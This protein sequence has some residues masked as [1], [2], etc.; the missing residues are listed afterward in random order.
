[1]LVFPPYCPMTADDARHRIAE[2]QRLESAGEL[3]DAVEA[4]RSVV[5]ELERGPG[6]V[7]ELADAHAGLIR[8]LYFHSTTARVMRAY[9]KYLAECA[10]PCDAQYDEIYSDGLIATDSCP[11]P[12]RRRERFHSLAGLFQRTRGLPGAV[13]ECGCFTGLSS[14]LLCR[15]LKLEDARFDGTGYEI[16]DSFAGLSAPQPEDEIPE[17]HPEAAALRANSV[18]GHFS[19]TLDRVKTALGEFPGIGFFPGW[20]PHAF[21][22]DSATRYRFV[23]LDVDL[24]QPTHDALQYF[25]PRLAPGGLIVCD[26]YGWPGAKK[27]IDEH[28]AAH[29]IRPEVTPHLQAYFAAP[30]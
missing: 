22:R 6:G 25:Y 18:P 17:D 1:M 27:A 21:P 29:G 28:C 4:Y 11:V 5:M 8:A 24:H 30:G 23:H 20:I 7:A 19:V 14:Y 9:R 3:G 15:Y 10:P 12:F 16:Y 2:A 26:D 13:A